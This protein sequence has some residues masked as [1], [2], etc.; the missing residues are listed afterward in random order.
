[1]LDG[2]EAIREQMGRLLAS[3]HF[4]HSKRYPAFLAHIVE[5]TLLGHVDELKER[6]IGIE[7][8]KRP[9]DYD[10]NADPIVR[11]AAGEI[12]KR[13]AQYYFEPGHEN[14]LRIELPAGHY[15]PTFSTPESS[16][17]S[18]NSGEPSRTVG[19]TIH[20]DLG[21]THLASSS[22][23]RAPAWLRYGV[24]CLTLA[25]ALMLSSFFYKREAANSPLNQFWSQVVDCKGPLLLG[26]GDFSSEKTR[27]GIAVSD[28]GTMDQIKNT[29][30]AYGK[31]YRIVDVSSA[32]SPDLKSNPVVLVVPFHNPWS[33]KLT[34]SL[35][36]S[37]VV[38]E[39]NKSVWIQDREF[40]TAKA[41]VA[42]TVNSGLAS[43]DSY[44]IVARFVDR[45]LD[46]PVVVVSGISP[47]ATI[48]AGEILT[49]PAYLNSLLRD[50]PRDWQSA[51]LEAVIGTQI[52]DHKSG[53]PRV[54]AVYFW[55]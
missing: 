40:P 11:V 50:A 12:R 35:R 45:S 25:A 27:T 52:I 34:G 21:V 51:N 16:A 47:Q 1:M 3:Q 8:Y 33:A 10:T 9:C 31:P 19:S 32:D 49:D 14:E 38:D 29:L 39:A 55:K 28:V 18:R 7:V 44:A 46:S 13:I 26:L 4:S 2:R 15:V 23:D 24:M 5:K 6:P 17:T 54:E 37:F 43:T 20:S 36:Y 41:W 48:A 22:R 42:H 30:G 53:P